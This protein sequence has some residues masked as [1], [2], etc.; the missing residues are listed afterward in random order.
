[1]TTFHSAE[2]FQIID[3]AGNAAYDVVY[4]YTYKGK[5]IPARISTDELKCVELDSPW[6]EEYKRQQE[7]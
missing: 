4:F 1:M 2:K 3:E 7:R 6:H 5:Y